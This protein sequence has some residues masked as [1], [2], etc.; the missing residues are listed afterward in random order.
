MRHNHSDVMRTRYYDAVVEGKPKKPKLLRGMNHERL[1]P[2]Q[3]CDIIR[4]DN[5]NGRVSVNWDR[6]YPPKFYENVN[7]EEL[8]YG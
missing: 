4:Q 3:A 6:A 5:G 8:D 1:C 2:C 7:W